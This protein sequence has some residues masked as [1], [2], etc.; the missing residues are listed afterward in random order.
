MR[1]EDVFSIV[2]KFYAVLLGL[3]SLLF[4][5]LI[6]ARIYLFMNPFLDMSMTS[7]IFIVLLFIAIIIFSIYLWKK[8]NRLLLTHSSIDFRSASF[9]SLGAFFLLIGLL[10]FSGFISSH[11]L[12]EVSINWIELFVNGLVYFLAGVMIMVIQLWNV[13]RI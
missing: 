12:A 13:K 8:A 10:G 7:F 2:L 6:L 4:G 9:I 1:K 5:Y 11:L 3:N